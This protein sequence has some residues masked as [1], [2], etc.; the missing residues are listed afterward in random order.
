MEKLGK[1]YLEKAENG[2]RLDGFIVR[3]SNKFIG[4]FNKDGKET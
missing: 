3:L 1:L 2:F 4:L